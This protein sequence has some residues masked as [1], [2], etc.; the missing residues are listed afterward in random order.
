MNEEKDQKQT[1]K[2][3]KIEVDREA[4][5]SVASCVDIAPEVFQLDQEGKAIVKNA[6]GNPDETILEAAQ[7]CPVN[8]I[9]LYDEKGNK[10]WP[11]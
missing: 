6:K 8:A 3:A 9:I 2:I 4:C 11:A 1:P 5:I 10:I 7:S